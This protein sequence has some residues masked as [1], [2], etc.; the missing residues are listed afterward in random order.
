[1]NPIRRR[2]LW[3][4]VALVAAAGLATTLVALALQRNIAYLYTPA[5]IL[6]GRA[7]ESVSSGEARFRLGGMVA[8]GSFQRDS[9]SLDSR[10]LVSDGD[11]VMPVVYTGLLPD[12]FRENQAVVATGRMRDGTFVAEEV[13]AKHDE[14]Y[15]PKEV[16][17]KMGLA[18]EKHGVDAPG[19]SPPERAP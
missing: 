4:V 13:L 15:V 12:L 5:E 1:M 9:G 17:D 6:D 2:R 18:H 8:E 19:A 16:A 11:A 14:T 3:F 10:F 7:G